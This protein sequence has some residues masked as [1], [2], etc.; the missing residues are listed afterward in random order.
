MTKGEARAL[1]L[2]WLDEATINGQTA[3]QQQTADLSDKFDYFLTGTLLY[4]AGYFRLGRQFVPETE[5][6]VGGLRR[7]EL[8]ADF[9]ELERV[10]AAG[11]DFYRPVEE[12]WTEGDRYLLVPGDLQ[13]QLRILYWGNPAAV[14]PEAE[15]ERV[16]EVLP[17]AEM[18][19]PLKTAADVTAGSEDTAAVSHYLEGRFSNMMVNL[20]GS[21]I[22]QTGQV[23][24]VFSMEG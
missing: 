14:E 6:T 16:L 4:L 8:P 15:E 11:P 10:V 7:V 21:G 2:R 24:T 13:G 22:P 19:V 9:R 23:G 1:F 3:S 20:L 17:Q 5:E 12:Y 18:L